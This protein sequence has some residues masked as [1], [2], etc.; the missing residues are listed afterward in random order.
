MDIFEFL[1]QKK[2][3]NR[4]RGIPARLN[5]VPP[6]ASWS[7]QS[8]LGLDR[9]PGRLPLFCFDRVMDAAEKGSALP[10]AL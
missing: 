5:L 1:F 3:R 9:P 2:Q 8:F 6:Q 10:L 4:P 7:G